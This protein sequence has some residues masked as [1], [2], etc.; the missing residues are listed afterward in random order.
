[1][2][3]TG[4]FAETNDQE[5]KQKSECLTNG[6]TIAVSLSERDPETPVP[7]IATAHNHEQGRGT[8]LTARLRREIAAAV[9]AGGR[10]RAG[11]DRVTS[12]RSREEGEEGE[13]GEDGK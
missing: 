12:V 10:G 2:F 9:A 4:V 11:A 7:A 8:E 3:S 1:M 5:I 6:Y 13:E